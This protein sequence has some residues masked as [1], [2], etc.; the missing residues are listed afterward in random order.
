MLVYALGKGDQWRL[1][2]NTM[3]TMSETGF[4]PDA[5]VVVNVMQACQ[6]AG[7]CV[8]NWGKHMELGNW[9]GR[10]FVWLSARVAMRARHANTRARA[11]CV[12]R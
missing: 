6:K 2:L 4:E 11:N 1:A 5:A 7:Q 10:R 3:H 9:G 8:W 12:A